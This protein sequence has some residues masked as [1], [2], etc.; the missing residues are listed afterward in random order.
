MKDQLIQFGGTANSNAEH[1]NVR[2]WIEMFYQHYMPAILEAG[3]HMWRDGRCHPYFHRTQNPKFKG[4]VLVS[5][6]QLA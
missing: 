6:V 2:N 4:R 5:C 3:D 1:D